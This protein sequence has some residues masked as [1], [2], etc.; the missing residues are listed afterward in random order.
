MMRLSLTAAV[1]VVVAVVVSCSTVG[2]S[3]GVS[4]GSQGVAL[5]EFELTNWDGSRISNE[6]LRGK[7][8]IMAFTYAKC[9]IACPMVTFQLKSLDEKVGSPANLSFLHVSVN[10]ADDTPEEILEHFAKHDIDPREDPRWL[11]AGGSEED[12]AAVLKKF[13]VEVTLRP[14]EEGV[15]IEHTIKILVI[16]ENAEQAAVFDTFYWDEGEMLDALRS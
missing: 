14:V 9:V 3:A 13:G 2:Y 15:L 10:P 8:T 7:K 16:D 12:V 1:G 5:P 11:F 6:S 4:S